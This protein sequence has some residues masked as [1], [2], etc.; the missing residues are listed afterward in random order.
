MSTKRTAQI[1]FREE[2]FPPHDPLHGTAH[3]MVRRV[4]EFD[5]PD[6]TARWEQT[7]YGHPGRF[8]EWE[9]RGIDARLQPKAA[10]L[11]AAAAAIGALL[12]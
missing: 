10:A 7:D 5:L 12:D 3:E 6:G 11:K 4:L 2:R 8:N 9:P 1:R